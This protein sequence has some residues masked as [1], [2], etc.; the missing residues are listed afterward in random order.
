LRVLQGER[1][2]QRDTVL[3]NSALAMFAYGNVTTIEAGV[4]LARQS[5]D[6]GQALAKLQAIQQFAKQ[7]KGVTQ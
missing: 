4:A 1:G 6:S 2:P 7:R 5:I 3:L